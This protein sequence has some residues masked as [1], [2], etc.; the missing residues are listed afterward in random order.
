MN[1]V[2]FGAPGAGK[3]TIASRLAE[4]LGI[5]HISIGQVFRDAAKEGTNDAKMIGELLAAGKPIPDEIA[6]NV[7]INH[8][9]KPEFE[10]GFIFDSPYNVA[11]TR[12]IDR[13]KKID[14]AINLAVSEEIIIDRL[15]TRRLCGQCGEVFNVRTMPSKVEG[16]CDKCG[17]DL[18]IRKDDEP[19]AIKERLRHYYKR[20]QP[21]EDYYRQTGA[22]VRIEITDGDAP[23]E[24]NTQ[25]VLDALK[26]KLEDD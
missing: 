25:K 21:L 23:P 26:K 12:A 4:K 22:L 15:S 19:E 13:A 20:A 24:A 7:I 8:L 14:A 10:K 6:I 16:K 1:L 9:K 2:I 3:G 18:I 11:Q 5:R 17:G